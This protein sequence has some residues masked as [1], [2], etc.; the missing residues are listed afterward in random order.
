[1][2]IKVVAPIFGFEDI[3][4]IE[5]SKIDDFFV[6]IESGEI[7]FTLID[8]IKLRE[9]QFEIPSYYKDIL[10]IDD[11]TTVD[12]YNIVT[13]S[14]DIKSSSINFAAPIVINRDR[15]LLAQ[16]VLDEIKYREFGLNELISD[17]L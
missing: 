13:I 4:E 6:K 1:M 2:N 8:P 7:S 12:I 16:I 15:A 11:N 10:K 14:S 5:F 17:Y 3:K 9:Y